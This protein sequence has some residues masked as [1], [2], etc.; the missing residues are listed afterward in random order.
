MKTHHIQG[1]GN[2]PPVSFFSFPS[3]LSLCPFFSFYSP[4]Y[5]FFFIFCPPSTPTVLTFTPSGRFLFFLLHSIGSL[6]VITP[7]MQREWGKVII[8]GFHISES[9]VTVGLQIAVPPTNTKFKLLLLPTQRISSTHKLL[10]AQ[11]I[12]FKV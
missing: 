2:I 12:I 5:F 1:S 10:Q 9:A 11:N 6:S 7:H 8:V 4:H 3:S